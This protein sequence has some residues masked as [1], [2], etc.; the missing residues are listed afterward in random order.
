MITKPKLKSSLLKNNTKAQRRKQKLG[1]KS[2]NLLSATAFRLID[3]GYVFTQ[4]CVEDVLGRDVLDLREDSF[5][6]D[7]LVSHEDSVSDKII[8]RVSPTN[9]S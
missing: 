1:K 6:W 2:P 4:Q 5:G 8:G 7:V 9:G 3:K